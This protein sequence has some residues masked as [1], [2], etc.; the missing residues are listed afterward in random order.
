MM[1]TN[2]K[3]IDGELIEPQAPEGPIQRK[4]SM[5]ATTAQVGLNER[6]DQAAIA[7]NPGKPDEFVVAMS[8]DA[9]F[10]IGQNLCAAVMHARQR[11]QPRP[12]ILDALGMPI[13]RN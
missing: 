8:L 2:G 10:A 7:F 3:A 13:R 1:E 11:A 4:S 6:C 12:I 9:A 5:T